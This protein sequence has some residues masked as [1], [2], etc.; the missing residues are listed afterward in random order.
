MINNSAALL[1]L[2]PTTVALNTAHQLPPL[3]FWQFSSVKCA[4]LS[5]IAI[6]LLTIP[7]CTV[8]LERIFNLECN[9]NNS[10]VSTLETSYSMLRSIEDPTRMERDAILRFNKAHIPKIF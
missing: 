2:P 5:E 3:Q 9:G 7:S 4:Q 8:S 10:S 6:E 1:G